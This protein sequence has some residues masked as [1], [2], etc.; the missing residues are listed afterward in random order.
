VSAPV[1]ANPDAPGGVVSAGAIS[2][3][4]LDNTSGDFG[5]GADTVSGREC[6]RPERTR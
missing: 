5:F 3:R 1:G 2:P 6:S 4:V